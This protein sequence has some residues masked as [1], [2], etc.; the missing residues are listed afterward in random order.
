MSIEIQGRGD[1]V[2]VV[3]TAAAGRSEQGQVKHRVEL[4]RDEAGALSRKLLRESKKAF[5]LDS[6][7]RGTLGIAVFAILVTTVICSVLYFV[8]NQGSPF[9]ARPLETAATIGLVFVATVSAIFQNHAP[10]LCNT[11]VVA[12]MVASVVMYWISVSGV[13][14]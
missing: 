7:F 6:T 13:T 10:R 11:L 1:S 3:V 4:D 9:L 2:Y 14:L 5:W 12:G 8:I